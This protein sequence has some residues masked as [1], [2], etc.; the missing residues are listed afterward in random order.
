VYE[1]GIT[2]NFKFELCN[3]SLFGMHHISA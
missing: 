1:I 2:Q 3:S